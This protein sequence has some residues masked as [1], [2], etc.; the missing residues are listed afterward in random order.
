MTVP[1]LL[2][3][4]EH[5]ALS[6]LELTG[7]VLDLGGDAR[8]DYRKIINGSPV[9]TTVNL[10]EKALPDILHDLEKVL[11]VGDASYDH[12]LLINVLEHVYEYRQLLSEAARVVRPSGTVIIVV[13]FLF[14]VHPSPQDFWRFSGT[15]LRKE[16]EVAGLS[17]EEIVPLGSGVVAARYVMLDRLLPS[18]FRLFGYWTARPLVFLV[19]RLF[20]ALARLLKKRY[21]PADYALGYFVKAVRT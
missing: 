13:P 19:D 12:V 5:R 9:F 8:S 20:T 4:A 14:P 18:V 17:V 11:P 10:D 16:C 6:T 1:T 15:A 7:T 21:E 3:Q 2:R